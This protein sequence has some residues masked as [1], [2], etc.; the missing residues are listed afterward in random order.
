MP[1]TNLRYEKGTQAPDV[2]GEG[3]TYMIPAD[4]MPD[5]I[6]TG[7]K[8]KIIIEGTCNTDEQ[9]LII[10]VDRISAEKVKV[11]TDPLQDKI[12]KGLTIEV[13]IPKQAVKPTKR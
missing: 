9:G 12:E 13:N 10:E 11:Y 7:E 1:M 3:S 8:Y 6:Q 5:G 2:K 4:D